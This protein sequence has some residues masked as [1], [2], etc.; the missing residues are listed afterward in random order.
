LHQPAGLKG[1]RTVENAM[2]LIG[3]FAIA[4][5][6]IAVLGSS[7]A[8]ADNAPPDNEDSRF[9]FHRTDD[10]YLRLDGR[11]GQVSICAR[12]P[13]GWLCQL[14]PDERATLE[15][16]IAR[17]QSD[18][19]ALKK[20]L[21]ARNLP[22]PGG[23]RPDPPSTKIDEPRVSLPSDAELNRMMAFFE[24]LWKRMVEMIV[25]TQRDMMKKS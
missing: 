10:G 2:I 3:R 13:A 21:L 22:L 6:V 16:E 11:S 8:R 7:A 12:R 17:L 15:S 4:V 19:A 25:T 5:A 23:M 24:K 9:T 14:V 1:H 20:E 18:N